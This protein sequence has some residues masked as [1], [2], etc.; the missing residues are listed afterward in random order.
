[1]KRHARGSATS[2]VLDAHSDEVGF[3]VQRIN[4][5][6][7]MPFLTLG[8]IGAANIPAHKV[9]VLNSKGRWIPGIIA[10]KPPHFMSAEEKKR[11]PEIKDMVIDVGAR[12]K[13]EAVEKF[14][15]RIAAPAVPDVDFEM[16]PDGETMIGKAF[17]DRIGCAAVLAVMNVLKGRDLSVDTTAVFSSQEEGGLRGAA[18]A[19][20]KLL[21]R[22]VICFEGCPADDTVMS[23]EESQTALGKGPMLRHIDI[24]AISNPR[25]QQLAL[26]IAAENGIPVQEA[27]RSGGGTNAMS[28]QKEGAACIVIGIPVRYSHSHYG[29]CRKDDFENAVRLGALLVTELDD[30]TIESF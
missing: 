29:F 12:S 5:N 27:V 24:S 8:S 11:L 30:E 17:D 23:S 10:A 21:P 14:G 18:A 19:A 15:M 26:D 4:E 1:M 3:I 16:A 6:G 9:R 22:A 13:A 7:T 25:F 2:L 28:Y 20:K